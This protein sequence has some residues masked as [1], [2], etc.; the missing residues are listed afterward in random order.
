MVELVQPV[1]VP[2]TSVAGALP[3]VKAQ[4]KVT[5]G[6]VMLMRALET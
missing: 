2:K 5:T 4:S 6:F 3:E 1:S